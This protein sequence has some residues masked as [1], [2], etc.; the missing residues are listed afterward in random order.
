MCNNCDLVSEMVCRRETSAVRPAP[1][2]HKDAGIEATTV[3]RGGAVYTCDPQRPWAQAVAVRGRSIISIGSEEKVLAAAGQVK[4]VV[5]LRG[6]M[7][8][9]GFVEAHIHPLVGGFLTAGVDLQVSTKVEALAAIADHAR[10]A[11]TGPV[12]GFGWRM[13]MFGPGGPCRED[14]DEILPDRPALLF[15]IDAHSLWVNSAA[16]RLAGISAGTPDPVPGFS[17]FDRDATGEP[18]GFIS[19]LPAM[20]PVIDA[21]APMTEDMLGRLLTDWLPK[22]A[23]AGI[24]AVFDAGMPPSVTIPPRWPTSIPIWK[25]RGGCH[26]GWLRPIWS[27]R[28]RSRVR[29]RRPDSC[30]TVWAPNWSGG[31]Y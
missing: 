9:P 19:E 27:S 13:D 24:T 6:R 7:L 8:L 23:A 2:S 5:E 15:A 1:E 3:F 11:P 17:F 4:D 18:N 22:A 21:I 26:S 28:R 31:A 30:G 29:W 12:R 10:S 20:L 14:L 16:L 25:R